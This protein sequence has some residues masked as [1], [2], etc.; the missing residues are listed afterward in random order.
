MMLTLDS[1][2][3]DEDIVSAWGEALANADPTGMSDS[4]GGQMGNVGY[5]FVNQ[6]SGWQAR[7]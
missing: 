5:S 3:S 1:S 7:A 6:G 2:V 4:V